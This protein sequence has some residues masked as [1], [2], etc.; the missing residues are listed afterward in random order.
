[1][2]PVLLV[3]DDPVCNFIMSKTL[4][5]LKPDIQILKALNGQEALDLL[6]NLEAKQLPLP[7]RIFLD[8]DMPVMNGFGFLEEMKK[9]NLEKSC[10]VAIVS[11]SNNPVD[12]AKAHLLGADDF[13]EKPVAGEKVA[14]FLE[15]FI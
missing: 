4:M 15:E 2:N 14:K 9:Q 5:L 3:D 11:S 10:H 8:I 13:I 7:K 6:L 12:I 1:M